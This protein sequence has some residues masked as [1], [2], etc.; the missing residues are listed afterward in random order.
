MRKKL[1]EPEYQIKELFVREEEG[2]EN[3]DEEAAHKVKLAS[4]KGLK[5][6]SREEI[7]NITENNE[8]PEKV[9]EYVN[10]EESPA[11]TPTN[12]NARSD[13]TIQTGPE[14]QNGIPEKI[15]QQRR[16]RNEIRIRKI[17]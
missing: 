4:I 12:A 6:I 9:N 8:V 10:T 16:S 11:F 15:I 5:P 13:R 2:T 14:R 1:K 7:T 17:K 3:S